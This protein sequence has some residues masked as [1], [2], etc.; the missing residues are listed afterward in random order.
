MS[1]KSPVD[2][3]GRWKNLFTFWEC[4][5][6]LSKN[7]GFHIL[8]HN[9][10]WKIWDI[11]KR[12]IVN[13]FVSSICKTGIC[14]NLTVQVIIIIKFLHGQFNDSACFWY[15]V[16]RRTLT[17]IVFMFINA[18]SL[19][20]Y[21]FIFWL[22]NPAIFNDDFW[23]RMVSLWIVGFCVLLQFICGFSLGTENVGFGSCTG[24]SSRD[25][26]A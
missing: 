4:S 18:I 26:K 24:K 13:K 1:R 7:F 14:W 6:Y 25:M 3:C 9:L 20:R 22:K 16:M 8:L 21:F 17:T 23:S 19:S 2:T 10:A 5:T 12:T 15:I 11:N